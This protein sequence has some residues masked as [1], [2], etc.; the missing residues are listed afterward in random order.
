MGTNAG[1]IN[2]ALDRSRMT[3]DRG[4]LACVNPTPNGSTGIN[5]SIVLDGGR[6]T[7][8]VGGRFLMPGISLVVN[9]M[10]RFFLDR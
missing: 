8:R 3:G 7:P 5:G 1:L 2:D 4:T 6:P 9:G 10:L